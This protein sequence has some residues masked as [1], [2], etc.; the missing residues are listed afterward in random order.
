M[1]QLHWVPSYSAF[2]KYVSECFSR[3]ARIQIA[4]FRKNVLW[5]LQKNHLK[6]PYM[7]STSDT[8][9][10]IYVSRLIYTSRVATLVATRSRRIFIQAGKSKFVP[11]LYINGHDQKKL[12][13]V[14]STLLWRLGLFLKAGGM[15]KKRKMLWPSPLVGGQNGTPV[16]GLCC[17]IWKKKGFQGIYS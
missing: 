1:S 13:G 9:Q 10:F 17:F 7:Y 3:S 6:P 12:K 16:L 11:K 14:E 4:G 15:N 2:G 8:M 5:L